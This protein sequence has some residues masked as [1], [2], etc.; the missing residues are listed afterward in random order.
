HYNEDGEIVTPKTKLYLDEE[1]IARDAQFDGYYAIVTSELH[2][3]DEDIVEAYHGLW[4]IEETFKIS[5]SELKTRPV[6]LNKEVHI[7][8]HFLICFVSMLLT[9]L[10]ELRMNEAGLPDTRPE[11]KPGQTSRFSS[12]ELIRTLREF[13]CSLISENLYN[14]HYTDDV[15]PGLEEVFKLDFS[16]RYRRL[17][18]IRKMIAAVKK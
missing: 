13:N 5:K 1:K 11:A 6:F 17:G 3:S 2:L 7:T 16:T 4:K 14:F 9:H 18:N 15:V 8:A 10:L 12:F